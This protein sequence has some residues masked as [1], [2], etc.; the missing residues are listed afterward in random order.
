MIEPTIF[1]GPPGTGKT[2]KLLDTV[3][4]EMENGVPPDRIGFMTFTKRGVEEAIS[5]ASYRFNLERSRFRFFNTLHSAAFRHLGLTT[6]QV[7]TGKRIHEFGAAHGLELHGGLSSDDGTYSN[8]YGDDLVLFLE[9]Y[10]RITRVPVELV[11]RRYDTMLTDTERAWRIIKAMREHKLKEGLVD[12]TDMIEMF[13]RDDDPPL[14]EALMIDEAQ[15]LSEL[16]W[17][18]VWLL[19]R[20]VKRMYIAGDDDQTIFTWAGASE[21]F[22]TL[23]GG[24]Q[25]LKQSYRVPRKVFDLAIRIIEQISNRRHKIWQARDAD[26]SYSTVEGISRVNPKTLDKEDGSVMMLGRTVKAIRSKFIPFCRMNGLLYRYFEN[27]SIKPTQA[28]AIDA[29]NQLQEG[30][31]IP[32]DDAVRIYDLLPSEGHRIKK[33]LVK[34]GFKVRLNRIADQ[35]E[36]PKLTLEQLRNDYGLLAEGPWHHVF[37]EIDPRDV[38][39]IGKVLNNGYSILDKPHIHIS[40]IHRVKG[41]QADKVILLSDTAKAAEHLASTNSDEETRVFYTGITRTKEDL[42]VVHPDKKRYFE[43]LFE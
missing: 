4:Q 20:H 36:P 17:E 35:P 12:F 27:P 39:Y 28:A 31:P 30:H 33:G 23:P 3:D 9:N 42:I 41:G 38:E 11:L 5:R 2:T 10:A 34:K 8:F 25:T 22:I 32:A 19:S 29:W 21:K 6:S 26:G 1:L 18:M 14:L 37:T 43:G 13:I 16:Q 24:E 40:T 15:D 7:F